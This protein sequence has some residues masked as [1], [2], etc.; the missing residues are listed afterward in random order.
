MLSASLTCPSC[1]AADTRA[2]RLRWNDLPMLVLAR[3]AQR[4]R[5]CRKRFYAGATVPVAATVKNKRDRRFHLTP[6][7]RR[8]VVELA[9]LAGMAMLFYVF[10]HYITQEHSSGGGDGACAPVSHSTAWDRFA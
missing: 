8:R 7:K 5:Q 1:G 10:L 9:L 2:A 4:C 3:R 6:A